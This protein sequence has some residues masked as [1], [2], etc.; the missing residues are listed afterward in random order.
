MLTKSDLTD[1]PTFRLLWD[2]AYK[3]LENADHVVFI[4]YSMPLTD[5]P[6]GFL[7][8]EAIRTSVKIDVVNYSNGN[9]QK[10][11]QK[12]ISNYRSVMPQLKAKQ[13]NFDGAVPWLRQNIFIE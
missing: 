7:F 1:Q 3:K 11:K 9:K 13:F 12:L 5:A 10:E 6:A 2:E 4:G 8:G